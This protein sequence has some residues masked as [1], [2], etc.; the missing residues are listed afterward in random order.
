MRNSGTN[1]ESKNRMRNSGTK[2]EGKSRTRM[3]NSG[4]RQ[5]ARVG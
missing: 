4:E 3:R 5:N 1:P 2:P